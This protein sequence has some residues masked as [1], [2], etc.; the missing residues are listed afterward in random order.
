MDPGSDTRTRSLRPRERHVDANPDSCVLHPPLQR[1]GRH[2]DG[3]LYYQKR[4]NANDVYTY[5]LVSFG[6]RSVTGLLWEMM[7]ALGDRLDSLD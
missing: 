3:L 4:A 7:D 5:E 1:I 6:A 2:V